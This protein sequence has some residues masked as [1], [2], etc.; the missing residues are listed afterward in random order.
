VPHRANDSYHPTSDRCARKEWTPPQ[1]QAVDRRRAA[2]HEAGHLT[3]LGSFG[4][5][6]WG[7]SI[8]PTGVTDPGR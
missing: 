7:A 8:F 5:A 2:I 3:V 6:T 4:L 1:V